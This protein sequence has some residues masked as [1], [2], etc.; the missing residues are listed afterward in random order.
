LAGRLIFTD[1]LGIRKATW[2]GARRLGSLLGD[3]I[4]LADFGVEDPAQGE[5]LNVAAKVVACRQAGARNPRN[6][7]DRDNEGHSTRLIL[8][9][10]NRARERTIPVVSRRRLNICSGLPPKV[11]GSRE[12]R[13]VTAAA[14]QIGQAGIDVHPQ[15]L[16]SKSLRCKKQTLDRFPEKLQPT[17]SPIPNRSHTWRR[18]MRDRLPMH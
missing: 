17:S 16:C 8:F 2:A 6:G 12:M 14:T 3:G 9:F 18:G 7:K 4:P 13:H 10:S 5:N 1:L 11:F 15:R